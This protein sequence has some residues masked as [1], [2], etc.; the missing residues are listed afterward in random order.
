M[1]G[2]LWVVVFK[3]SCKLL[4]IPWPSRFQQRE[5]APRRL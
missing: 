5:G 2:L 3:L 1:A 4:G